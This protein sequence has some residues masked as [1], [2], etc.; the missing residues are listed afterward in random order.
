MQMNIWSKLGAI[1]TT[2]HS[3][4]YAEALPRKLDMGYRVS[5]G[6]GPKSI[7]GAPIV[8]GQPLKDDLGG[9]DLWSTEFSN[10]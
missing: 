9:I 6:R 8:L 3:E 2:F 1:S 5:T 4:L 7:K 10:S